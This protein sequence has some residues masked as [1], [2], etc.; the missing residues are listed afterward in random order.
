MAQESK[1]DGE[2]GDEN[3]VE[4]YFSTDTGIGALKFRKRLEQ[5]QSQSKKLENLQFQLL[6]IKNAN[7]ITPLDTI[8][9]VSIIQ[10]QTKMK[11]KSRKKRKPS[12]HRVVFK[13][14][15][16]SETER[17]FSAARNNNFASESM[18]FWRDTFE[19]NNLA[20]CMPIQLVSTTYTLFR[21]TLNNKD[22]IFLIVG[23]HN[24]NVLEYRLVDILQSMIVDLCQSLQINNKNK[25]KNINSKIKERK[26][27][28]TA[29]VE[30]L[31]EVFGGNGDDTYPL[32]KTEFVTCMR[33]RIGMESV[34]KKDT[35]LRLENLFESIINATDSEY[36]MS[37]QSNN[38][39]QK[40]LRF[41]NFISY[42]SPN[43][44]N[45]EIESENNNNNKERL[46]NW[47][48]IK[49]AVY[50]SPLSKRNKELR[51]KENICASKYRE[52][53]NKNT[54]YFDK[55]TISSDIEKLINLLEESVIHNESNQNDNT[56]VAKMDKNEQLFWRKKILQHREFV[57][58]Y[59]KMIEQ[60]KKMAL[61][62][63]Q[64]KFTGN[65]LANKMNH[66]VNQNENES[67]INKLEEISISI[68]YDMNINNNNKYL[69][70]QQRKESENLKLKHV[71]R[72]LHSLPAQNSGN[73]DWIN[74]SSTHTN[75]N[76]ESTLQH[77]TNQNGND[78]DSLHTYQN[79][80]QNTNQNRNQVQ[81]MGNINL[82]YM[83]S[84]KCCCYYSF[85]GFGMICWNAF[86]LLFNLITSFIFI[87][88]LI[89]VYTPD[90]AFLAYAV[91]IFTIRTVSDC[92]GFRTLYI[93]IK[94]Q[95]QAKFTGNI[96]ANKMHM[97]RVVNQNEN[98]AGNESDI[99]K[100]EG[101]LAN[102]MN[103]ENK[104]GDD[105][106]QKHYYSDEDDI[107]K[108]TEISIQGKL[109]AAIIANNHSS[110]SNSSSEDDIDIQPNIYMNLN[111]THIQS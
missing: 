49:Y 20:M 8:C 1:Y 79:T 48:D 62:T 56:N 16:E 66:V 52:K 37:I 10:P 21:K 30:I 73:D 60:H 101:L 94:K 98:S 108:L 6:T 43:E 50:K 15:T 4:D 11:S 84:L 22:F 93:L 64:F 34:W 57:K 78:N 65:I 40:C 42:F 41:D 107:S 53:L 38:G 110:T 71:H 45:F 47:K 9:G 97:N 61:K 44:S 74:E 3:E 88:F 19:A 75:T 86:M 85:S 102:K 70:E 17:A 67:D 99:S 32:N 69:N 46:L 58:M 5:L 33:V 29:M 83:K 104:D 111:N 24:N 7:Y 59:Q 51:E 105:E 31:E 23:N 80:N 25:N 81:F 96:L 103:D 106:E 100:L 36:I 90:Q 63:D 109:D 26:M 89:S 68:H 13:L 87:F 39:T 95:Y 28:L 55:E 91:I 14:F 35:K 27:S 92:V 54:L 2:S 72:L 77:I 82:S 18:S 12:D 76:T